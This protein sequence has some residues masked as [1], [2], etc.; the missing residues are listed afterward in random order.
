MVHSIWYHFSLFS[1]F[2]FG[3]EKDAIWFNFYYM[4]QFAILGFK[5][6]TMTRFKIIT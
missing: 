5:I 6:P 2:C 4:V 1:H 3:D